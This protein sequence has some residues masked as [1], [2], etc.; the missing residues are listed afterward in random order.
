MVMLRILTDFISKISIEVGCLHSRRQTFSAPC[1]TKSIKTPVKRWSPSLILLVSMRK[2]LTKT[3]SKSHL[4]TSTG[5]FLAPLLLERVDNPRTYVV[6]KC[7]LSISLR[8]SVYFA[9]VVERSAV[10]CFP[11]VV[12]SL[13]INSRLLVCRKYGTSQKYFGQKTARRY[14]EANPGLIQSQDVSTPFCVTSAWAIMFSW[15]IRHVCKSF[16]EGNNFFVV[17]PQIKPT[18]LKEN[19][20]LI[21][22]ISGISNRYHLFCPEIHGLLIYIAPPMQN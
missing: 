4:G 1:L 20:H 13:P 19:R 7:F 3:Y 18:I 17:T 11:Y 16:H 8:R 21:Q 10:L 14:F 9:D 5:T 2:H 6:W 12:L 22:Y 15:S